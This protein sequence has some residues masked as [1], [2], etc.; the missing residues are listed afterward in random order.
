MKIRR[1]HITYIIHQF[2]IWVIAVLL[3][4]PFAWMVSSSLKT[5][6]EVFSEKMTWIPDPVHWENYM[7][8]FKTMPVFLYTRN[9]ILIT[10]L[11]IVGYLT[12]GSLVA[13]AFSRLRWKGRDFWF[14]LMLSTMMLPPQVTIIPL[15]VIFRNLKWI[16]T[17]KPLIVPAYL[18]GWP[19]FIFLMRQ[20]F[21]TIPHELTE[22][23]KV[24]GAGHFRI[25]S[26]LIL[27]LSKPILAVVAIF[28]FLLHWNDF[29]GPLIYLV[30]DQKFT[31]ALGLMTFASKH[32]SEWS[33]LMAVSLIMLLPTL[34]VFFF[35]QRYFVESITLTGTKA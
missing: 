32:Q 25:Y 5:P 26:Q 20:Y 22:A 29:F 30:E 24:D 3:L 10:F 16:N 11:C 23:G 7:K 35:S 21:L 34:V 28:A 9:T 33:I 31:L 14:F 19:F 8:A 6:D 17:F 27:P 12:S 1:R 4:I 13:Y 18:T 2:I 15:Y